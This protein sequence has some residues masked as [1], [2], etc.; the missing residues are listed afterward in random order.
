M[1]VTLAFS[2]LYEIIEMIVAKLVSPEAGDAYLGTQGDPFDAVMDMT[3]AFAGAVV[4]MGT[5]G[6]MR[7]LF[8][9]KAELLAGEG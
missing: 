4:C 5:T 7:K 3:C 8:H 2:A 1:D 6:M 9:K